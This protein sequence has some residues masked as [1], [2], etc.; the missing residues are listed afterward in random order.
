MIPKDSHFSVKKG[1]DDTSGNTSL[2]EEMGIGWSVTSVAERP[3]G[4]SWGGGGLRAGMALLREV[5]DEG[6]PSP[7]SM[8]WSGGIET[9]RLSR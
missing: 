4:V 9:F 3:L 7:A 1:L 6:D 8:L 2:P 5:K